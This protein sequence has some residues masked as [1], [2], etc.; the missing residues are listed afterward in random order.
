MRQVANDL[1]RLPGRWGGLRLAA[2]A[3]LTLA[4]VAL[5]DLEPL[6]RATAAVG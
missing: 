5:L 3:A 6:E 4:V 1:D 2:P